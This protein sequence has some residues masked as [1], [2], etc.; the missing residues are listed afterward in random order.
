MKDFRDYKTAVL[1]SLS[2]LCVSGSTELDEFGEV[3]ES[4]QPSKLVSKAFESPLFEVKY[5]DGPDPHILAD[6][7]HSLSR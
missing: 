6:P 1:D 4:K 2:S 3:T 7:K 5:N